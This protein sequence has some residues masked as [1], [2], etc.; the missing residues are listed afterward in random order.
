ME[1]LLHIRKVCIEEKLLYL[2]QLLC[3]L[4]YGFLTATWNY[5][6]KKGIREIGDNGKGIGA[7]VGHFKYRVIPFYTCGF[8]NRLGLG[9]TS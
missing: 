2:G 8:R 7:L 3:F 6:L 9:I 1:K 5:F 4:L